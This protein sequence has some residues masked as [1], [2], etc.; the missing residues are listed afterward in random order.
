MVAHYLRWYAL[1]VRDNV[2]VSDAA[3]RKRDPQAQSLA[4]IGEH[5]LA[6]DYQPQ[7]DANVS[8]GGHH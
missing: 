1:R 3:G 6:E 8:V 4:W 7:H 5:D 2:N